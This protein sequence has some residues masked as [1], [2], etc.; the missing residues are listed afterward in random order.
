MSSHDELASLRQ[1][2][3][4]TLI[5][6]QQQE[7]IDRARRS[8]NMLSDGQRKKRAEEV[9]DATSSTYRWLT[10]FTKTY[11]PHWKEQKLAGP[12]LPFPDWPFFPVLLEYLEDDTENVKLIE[13]SRTM[14]VTWAITG[15]FTLQAMLV[16]EREIV[17]QTMTDEKGEQPI[18][19]AKHLWQS[20]PEWLRNEFPLK[21]GKPVDKQPKN[22]FRFANGSV[23]FGIPAGAGKIRSYHPW[24]Y[25]NDETAFQAEAGVAYDEALSACKKLVLNSTAAAGWYFD[26]TN[27]SE[28]AEATA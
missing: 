1:A 20:Q 23:I 2:A 26:F 7:E 6:E 18:E 11:N 15:Y 13:K 8:S 24:G 9:R 17:I 12:Y 5:L 16:P 21:E 19:Y 27:D 22:E 28:M 4:A 3:L 10:K 25:F 14:M